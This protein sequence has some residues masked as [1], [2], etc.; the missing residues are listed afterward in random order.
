MRGIGDGFD[1]AE[2]ANREGQIFADCMPTVDGSGVERCYFSSNRESV[3]QIRV[4]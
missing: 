1:E 2:M 4:T 3:S